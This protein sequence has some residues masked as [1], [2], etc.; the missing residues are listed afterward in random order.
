MQ[1]VCLCH[2]IVTRFLSGCFLSFFSS[3]AYTH[4]TFVHILIIYL[5]T[6]MVW[7]ISRYYNRDEC[8]T[9]LLERIAWEISNKVSIVINV[10]RILRDP[11]G[12]KKIS[13]AKEVLEK[14]K[15]VR[16]QHLHLLQTLLF[17]LYFK[18]KITFYYYRCN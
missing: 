15:E 8:M 14:W 6:E 10:K 2:L 11:D 13:E 18:F 7:I 17:L 5:L 4:G 9:P 1:L 3:S 16:T 12:M